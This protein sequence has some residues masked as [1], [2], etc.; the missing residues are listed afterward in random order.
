MSYRSVT[1]DPDGATITV[2]IVLSRTGAR[3]SAY[4]TAAAGSSISLP[5]T[6]STPTVFFLAQGHDYDVISTIGGTEIDRTTVGV[7]DRAVN[8]PVVRPS[9][10]VGEVEDLSA[11][12]PDAS[13][14][15]FDPSGL[16]NTDAVEVQSALEDLDGAIS[17]GSGASVTDPNPNG[18]LTKL[19]LGP[20]EID[21]DPLN[22]VGV[23]TLFNA[24]ADDAVISF[25]IE[26]DV[27]WTGPT[28]GTGGSGKLCE[29]DANGGQFGNG[30]TNSLSSTSDVDGNVVTPN[31][32]AD[33][34]AWLNDDAP[35]VY[36]A[37][38]SGNEEA[39]TGGH[40]FVRVVIATVWPNY[41]LNGDHLPA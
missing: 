24:K 37:D 40:G 4:T 2:D 11:T 38:F 9:L 26:V 3:A 5:A 18:A 23:T 29:T 41:Y 27:A 34:V 6:V 20:F 13:D 14:V 36:V 16:D 31:Y 7:G 21:F 22:M 15:V 17:A 25:G 35:I 28:Y 19:M 32:I 8:P 39:P 12:A 1:V 10:S 33:G 30:G